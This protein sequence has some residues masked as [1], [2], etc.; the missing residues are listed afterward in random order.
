MSRVERRRVLTVFGTR[1]EAIKLAPVVKK[2]EASPGFESVVCVT[3][4]HRQMLDQVLRAFDIHPHHDLD[5]MR[6]NQDLF[7]VTVA[8]LRGMK[9]VLQTVEPHM[10]LVQGDTTTAFAASLAAFYSRIPVGH[11]EAGLRT[12]NKY[13]PFPEEV[14]RCMTSA[15]A[16]LHFAPT[17]WAARN[18]AKEGIPEDKVF[19][20]GNTVVDA[21]I[22]ALSIIEKGADL[23]D[24]EKAMSFPMKERQIILITGHRRE[25][26]GEGFRSICRAIRRLVEAFPNYNFVYP[27][28]LNPNVRK[29]VDDILNQ[30]RLPNIH[31]IEPLGYLPFVYLMKHAHLILT[32]SGGIQEEA[33]TFRKP[34]LVM[35]DTTERPEGVESGGIRLVGHCEESIFGECSRLLVS[36]SA[37]EAM[38]VSKNPYGDGRAAERIVT[39]LEKVLATPVTSPI[40]IRSHLQTTPM[41]KD[42][43]KSSTRA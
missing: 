34:V 23:G 10:V 32:D 5:I 24:L 8:V 36:K 11:V 12:Y 2:L 21:L 40:P 25:S 19:I 26:F 38:V 33:L 15:I 27:V 43:V 17:E 18:L 7:D 3:G 6:P 41:V 14:N 37:Y 28:H 39:I 31:L 35:R 13:S 42:D 20:T 29:P 1:P 16:D 9:G 30:T 4:Q 22:E